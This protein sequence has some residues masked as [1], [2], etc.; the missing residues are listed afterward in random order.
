MIRRRYRCAECHCLFDYDHHPSLEADPLPNFCPNPVCGQSLE[1]VTA[2]LVAP[3]LAT[4][5]IVGSVDATIRG[6]EEGAEIRAQMA[7]EMGGLDSSEA[8]G[9][10]ITNQKDNLR[11]GDSSDIPV[12]NDVTRS[13]A[14]QPQGTVGFQSGGLGYSSTVGQGPYP[15]AGL[16]AMIEAQSRFRPAVDR[17]A[18]ETL[19]PGYRRRA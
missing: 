11:A 19:Q 10:R 3:H 14:I 5:A 9:L 13:M 16:R 1:N 18:L 2:A 17:P 6:M 12:V 15:N 7:Q 4:K 8:A